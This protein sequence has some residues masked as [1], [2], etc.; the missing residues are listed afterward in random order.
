MTRAHPIIHLMVM[1]ALLAQAWIPHGFMPDWAAASKGV[2]VLKVCSSDHG[3]KVHGSDA[4]ASVALRNDQGF[5]QTNNP[6]HKTSSQDDRE[7]GACPYA[8]L[9]AVV[10][11]AFFLLT[12]IGIRRVLHRMR[13]PRFEAST[14]FDNPN[15]WPQAPP[16]LIV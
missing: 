6:H 9:Q 10:W 5:V 2:V 8:V 14:F 4:D 15:A 11:C 3:T 7:G 16:S 13:L 1:L 12:F